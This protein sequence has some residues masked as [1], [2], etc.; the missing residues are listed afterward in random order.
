MEAYRKDNVSTHFNEYN[1]LI[2]AFIVLYRVKYI[3]YIRLIEIQ[4]VVFIICEY[5]RKS[6]VGEYQPLL[7]M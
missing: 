6:Y 2:I 1:R 7:L 3:K 4:M 5:F